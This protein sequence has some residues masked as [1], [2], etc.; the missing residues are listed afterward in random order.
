MSYRFE[1]RAQITIRARH[2]AAGMVRLHKASWSDLPTIH[3]VVNA[4][5]L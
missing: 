2:T 1:A 5:C 4:R 3:H